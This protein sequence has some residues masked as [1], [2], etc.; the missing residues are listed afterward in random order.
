MY[1]LARNV[2][3]YIRLSAVHGA[4][5][6]VFS[7]LPY[8][9]QHH[10]IKRCPSCFTLSLLGV[11]LRV[12]KRVDLL[13]HTCNYK[14]TFNESTYQIFNTNT[15]FVLAIFSKKS[16]HVIQ[17]IHPYILYTH[18]QMDTHRQINIHMHTHA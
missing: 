15:C 1:G 16:C 4:I 7:Q 13:F 11:F 8:D 5:S 12:A 3:A 10:I 18:M 6:G 17:S 14:A 9:N 2:I